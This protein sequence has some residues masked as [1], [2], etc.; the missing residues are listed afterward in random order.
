MSIKTKVFH[1]I[2]DH[3]SIRAR[4]FIIV[5]T[6]TILLSAFTAFTYKEY[7]DSLN[8]SIADTIDTMAVASLAVTAS[9]MIV[10][11]SS[12][13]L[14]EELEAITS[15]SDIKRIRILDKSGKERL[16]SES[17]HFDPDMLYRQSSIDLV[18][19][20]ITPSSDD[21]DID[22]GITFSKP[23]LIGTLEYWV[24]TPGNHIIDSPIFTRTFFV[25]IVIIFGSIPIILILSRTISEPIDS[26]GNRM[27]KFNAGDYNDSLDAADPGKDDI[28]KLDQLVAESMKL[29][30]QNTNDLIEQKQ[31]AEEHMNRAI[32]ARQDAD[33]AIEIKNKFIANISREIKTPLTGIVAGLEL[34]EDF[35]ISFIDED[36]N[37]KDVAHRPSINTHSKLVMH[38]IDIAKRSSFMLSKSI[39]TLLVSTGESNRDIEITPLEFDLNKSLFSILTKYRS[40]ARM[41]GISFHTNF[42]NEKLNGQK[43]KVVSDWPRIAVI[44]NTFIENA[45]NSTGN[46]GSIN[47]DIAVSHW[48]PNNV[49]L[50]IEVLD[51]GSGINPQMAESISTL[52][53]GNT[54]KADNEVHISSLQMANVIAEKLDAKLC[55]EKTVPGKGSAFS[56]SITLPVCANRDLDLKKK[57]IHLLYVDD[58]TINRQIFAGY[59]R[60]ENIQITLASDGAEGYSL[61]EKGTFN[62]LILDCYMPKMSGYELSEKIRLKDNSVVIIAITADASLSN[63]QKCIASGMDYVFTK[64]YTKE[65]I[66]AIQ[67]HI[68]SGR[69]KLIAR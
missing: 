69:Q 25:L 51:T 28:G 43:L 29:V 49:T 15:K 47:V 23:R 10:H 31:E 30:I 1:I 60:V 61:W 2:R 57:P 11:G 66:T 9:H 32:A 35:A 59:C 44:L 27:R 6:P 4:L 7:F 36:Y 56:F 54:T 18:Y 39:D 17:S 45:L 65:T 42:L 13:R 55:L 58:N 67:E 8:Q 46:D 53:T 12:T 20:G 24:A 22:S 64:P 68:L 48:Q 14:L 26:I 21:I 16:T 3:L 5:F 52:F 38:S 33:R 41:H 19:K 40:I 50:R 62:G 34:I 63:R 37:H